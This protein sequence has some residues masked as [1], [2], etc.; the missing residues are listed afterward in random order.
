MADENR[1]NILYIMTDQQRYDSLG[2]VGQTPCQ[3]PH[4]DR[5]SAEGMR[6]DNAYSICALCSPARTSMLTGQYPHNHRMWNN[7][8]MMQWAVRDLPDEVR[9]ISEDLREEGY[10]CGY[11]GKWHCGEEKVPSTY[12]FQGMDVPNYGN[13]YKT[14]EYQAYLRE[15]NMEASE[16]TNAAYPWAGGELSGPP[17]AGA[18][19]FIADFALDLLERFSEE[20]ERT[21]KPFMLFVSF[22][23]P[24]HPCFVPEPYAS[25]YDPSEVELWETIHDE[26]AGKPAI[27][28]RFTPSFYPD[29]QHVSDDEWRQ[30]IAWY[31]GFCTYVDDQVGRLLDALDAM[32]RSEDTA[33]LFSTDHGDMTGAHGGMWDKGPFMYEETYHIPLMARVPGITQPGGVCD[34]LVSNMDLAT[35]VLDLVGVPIPEAH[36]GRSL[37]PLFRDPEADWRDDLM[38]EFHGHRFLYSQRMVRWGDYKYVFNAPDEDELYDL[39]QDPY[40]TTNVMGD[41][42]YA[43]VVQAGRRRLWQWIQD[44][45]DPL[46]FAAYHM[47]DRHMLERKERR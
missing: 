15:H 33:V 44:S 13:P 1:P 20:R 27:H 39:G 11:S 34:R 40:E 7:N 23:G 14:D 9:L 16:R 38:C 26:L 12:G 42:R 46:A 21:G 4:L 28:R 47:L 43:E 30:L 22:W 3:T 29:A 19:Y 10:S 5:L 2:S 24:H 41:A 31:W 45:D 32:G 8:D 6:F 18:P 17:E 25:M 36:D 35:T 37:V